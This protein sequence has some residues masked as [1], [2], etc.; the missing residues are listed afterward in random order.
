MLCIDKTGHG[1]LRSP[2]GSFQEL[3]RTSDFGASWTLLPESELS[4][5]DD[6]SE[7]V[8]PYDLGFVELA[9]A[10]ETGWWIMSR[11]QGVVMS[12]GS[13]E[14]WSSFFPVTAVTD[15]EILSDRIAWLGCVDG[16][17]HFTNDQGFSWKTLAPDC[18]CRVLSI[19][20]LTDTDVLVLRMRYEFGTNTTDE[21][22]Q[23]QSY[24]IWEEMGRTGRAVDHWTAARRRLS[25][26][27]PELRLIRLAPGECLQ[28]TLELPIEDESLLITGLAASANTV[29][30]AG[31]TYALWLCESKSIIERVFLFGNRYSYSLWEFMK[32]PPGAVLPLDGDVLLCTGGGTPHVSD[33]RGRT[34]QYSNSSCGANNPG[35]YCF[36][37]D[38]RGFAVGG[39]YSATFTVCE[40]TDSGHSWTTKFTM[41]YK[42]E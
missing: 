24:A 27:R 39:N 7:R 31:G 42:K 5:P 38:L 28:H 32:K 37:D 23:R 22:V 14:S 15:V 17:L 29:C 33:D 12:Y 9:R 18:D 1:V 4:V 25:Y 26:A 16:T 20:R 30:L 21:Q 6:F 40:T 41:P 11:S 2:F 19:V 35:N 3:Y 8:V 36:V 13:G 34:W 10:H